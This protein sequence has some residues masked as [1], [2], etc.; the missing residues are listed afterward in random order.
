MIRLLLAFASIA[1]P[2]VLIGAEGPNI[3]YILVDD[4]GYGD[5]AVM[6]KRR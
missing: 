4:L 1:P 3:I 6:V 2:G 5:L